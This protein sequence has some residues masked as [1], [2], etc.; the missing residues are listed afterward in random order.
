MEITDIAWAAGFWEGEGSCRGRYKCS[1]EVTAHQTNTAPL[2]KLKRLFGGDVFPNHP[3]RYNKNAA[4]SWYWYVGSYQARTFL[5]AIRPYIVSPYKR[6][7]LDKAA[8]MPIGNRSWKRIPEKFIEIKEAT[9]ELKDGKRNGKKVQEIAARFGVTP[10]V[11]YN[12]RE[13]YYA[14]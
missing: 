10:K 11:V 8:S 5:E 13:G 9:K 1:I 12:I 3:E 7:Q 6:A 4:P 14:T 2:L